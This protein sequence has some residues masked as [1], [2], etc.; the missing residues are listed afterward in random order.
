MKHTLELDTMS[1][2]FINEIGYMEDIDGVMRHPNRV[3][4]E[5]HVFVYVMEG[6]LQIIEDEQL[7]DLKKGEYLFLKKNVH[8]YGRDLYQKGSEWYY[9][10]FFTKELTKEPEEFSMYGQTSLFPLDFYQKKLSLPK[11][12]KVNQSLYLAK[13]LK[14]ILVQYESSHPLRA[15]F[16]SIQVYEMF[17]ELYSHSKETTYSKK[18]RIVGL[19]IELFHEQKGKKLSSE[20]IEAK[21][22][23]NYSYLSS[24]FKKY[25]GKS[26]VHYQNE[27]M[28][29]Q[30][31]QLFKQ[32]K[33]NVSEVS[34]QLGFTNP[35]YFSR[36]FKKVTG[37]APIAY[38][39]QSY[40]K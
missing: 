22:G 31:I 11:Y 37:M 29:E 28:I 26:I 35:F 10:H 27:L 15:L 1:I 3:M 23:M 2:P 30:A 39:Q 33:Y 8:H 34:D 21:I 25:T 20:E 6:K 5:L 4:P 12:G 38:V 40:R 16:T 19:L 7:Y 24:L 17:M 13:K 14:D 9:I 32:G 36:V 18:H